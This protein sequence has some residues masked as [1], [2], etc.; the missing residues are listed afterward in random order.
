MQP[1]KLICATA[2]GATAC[3]R[4]IANTHAAVSHA[5]GRTVARHYRKDKRFVTHAKAGYLPPIRPPSSASASCI[6]SIGIYLPGKSLRP[7]RCS[8]FFFV[9]HATADVIFRI[10]GI[11]WRPTY[12]VYRSFDL[13]DFA[14][15]A[16]HINCAR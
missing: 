1:R 6:N 9:S 4:N 13:V 14:Y 5:R 8:L 10:C 16:S 7:R 12:Y 2:Q 15:R 11:L 3:V